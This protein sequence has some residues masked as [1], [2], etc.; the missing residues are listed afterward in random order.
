[1]EQN[2]EPLRTEI[3]RCPHCHKFI[4]HDVTQEEWE[5]GERYEECPHCD[6]CFDE[7]NWEIVK[8]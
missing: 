6:K 1:M 8:L 7:H 5:D 3:V 2:K 4:S